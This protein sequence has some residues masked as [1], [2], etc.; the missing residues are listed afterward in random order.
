MATTAIIPIHGHVGKT[1]K[2]VLNDCI[3]YIENPEKTENKKYISIYQCNKE[4]VDDEFMINKEMYQLITGRTKEKTENVI[5]YM[6]R[7]SFKPEEITPEKANEIGYQL[8][9]NFTKGNHQFVVATHIDKAHI[10]N[11]IIFNSVDLDCTHKFN[12]VKNSA[13]ILRKESDLL[14]KENGLSIVENP[15][16][17]GKQY[18]E[19]LEEKNGNSWKAKLKDV[20]NNT[21]PYVNNFDELL[22]S[23]EKAGYEIKYGKHISFRAK[24]QKR[25]TRLDK[26][27]I[28]YSEINL[29]DKFKIQNNTKSDKNKINL[30]IDIQEKL[31]SGKG[32]A[33]ERWA[34]LFNLKEAAKTLNYLTENNITQYSILE[35]QTQEKIT[36]FNFVSNKIKQLEKE[37]SN[38]ANLKFHIINYIKTKDTYAKFRK[39]KNQDKFR[40]E[41]EKEI[42]LYESAKETFQEFSTK[43]LPS[44]SSLNKKYSDL[45]EE[46][47]KLYNKYKKLK[48][49]TQQIQKIKQN[50]EII[51]DINKSEQRTIQIKKQEKG[52]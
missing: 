28:D 25:F 32:A 14:C 10:H 6:L 15:K 5:A 23:I 26:L 35:Q 19:W 38:T 42:L 21:L 7:Q 20:I 43:K 8:A 17:K 33:Y 4:T 1:V 47:R 13:E 11:H 44:I 12:N 51:L 16:G 49:E 52:L 29:K 31:N 24:E 46:K 50:I 18:K 40:A 2:Q 30:I 45:L 22:L 36:E 34:K 37:L 48:S 9:M 41:H 3:D 27:G 39:S